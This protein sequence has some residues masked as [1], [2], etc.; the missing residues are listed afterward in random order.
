MVDVTSVMSSIALLSRARQLVPALG[1]SLTKGAAGRIAVVGGSAEVRFFPPPS[2][3]FVSFFM[4]VLLILCYLLLSLYLTLSN[5]V[6][7]MFFS[8]FFS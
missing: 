4:L 3:L 2:G 6:L 8:D 7:Q 5:A 1:P